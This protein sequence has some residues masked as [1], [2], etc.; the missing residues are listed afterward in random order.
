ML[1]VKKITYKRAVIVGSEQTFGKGTV[2]KVQTLSEGKF[3]DITVN[4]LIV[5]EDDDNY[6]DY[7][8]S[9]SNQFN[10]EFL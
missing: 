7:S 10:K 5:K 1:S 4:K 6:N 2:Q 3:T 9:N 8:K